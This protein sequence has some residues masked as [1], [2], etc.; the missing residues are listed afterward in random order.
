MIESVKEVYE[1]H[2]EAKY[3][4]LRQTSALHPLIPG[5]EMTPDHMMDVEIMQHGRRL[6][7]IRLVLV[8]IAQLQRWEATA[9]IRTAKD[10]NALYTTIWDE[11]HHKEAWFR[12][13]EL[14]K[15]LMTEFAWEHTE[16][17]VQHD[18][19]GVVF[20]AMSTVVD[21]LKVVH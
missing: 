16:S 21:K 15:P 20:P 8:Y 1:E 13:S 12:L 2:T 17:S 18:F 14:V 9:S 5:S 3:Q 19:I 6:F 7:L 4:R 10:G 11:K